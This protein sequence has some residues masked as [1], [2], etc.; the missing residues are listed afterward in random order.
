[1]CDFSWDFLGEENGVSSNQLHEFSLTKIT[2]FVI[3]I[4]IVMIVAAGSNCRRRRVTRRHCRDLSGPSPARA[5]ELRADRIEHGL[6]A[7]CLG[8]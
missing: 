5:G 6:I 1:V 3:V 2:A 4:V 8:D 7:A